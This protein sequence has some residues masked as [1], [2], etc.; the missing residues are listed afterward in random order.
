MSVMEEQIARFREEGFWIYGPILTAEELATLQERIDALAA[1]EGPAA[2]KIGIRLEAE[3][4]RGGRQEVARRDQVWQ[5]M[6]ATRHDEAIR[7]HAEN[8]R[9]LEVVAALL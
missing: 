7:R 9:I 3:A 1:G 4:Q 5:I 8:P 2:E 6:G